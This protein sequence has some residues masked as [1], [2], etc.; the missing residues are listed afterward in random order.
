LIERSRLSRC[1]VP[2]SVRVPLDSVNHP[3]NTTA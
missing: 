2:C 3:S 1:R